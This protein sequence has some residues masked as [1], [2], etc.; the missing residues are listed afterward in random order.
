ME[1][2]IEID[3]ENFVSVEHLSTLSYEDIVNLIGDYC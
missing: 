1:K 3:G 2:I